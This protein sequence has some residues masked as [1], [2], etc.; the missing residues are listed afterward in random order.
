MEVSH[1]PPRIAFIFLF[2]IHIKKSVG[3]SGEPSQHRRALAALAE[4]PGLVP[5]TYMAIHN[6]LLL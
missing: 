2:L 4:D 5:S 6:H 1:F 3:G